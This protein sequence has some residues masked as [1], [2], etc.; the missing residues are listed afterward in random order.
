MSHI[1]WFE[2]LDQRADR[3]ESISFGHRDLQSHFGMDEENAR[4]INAGWIYT[5]DRVLPV[6]ERVALYLQTVTPC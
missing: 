1:A 5:Q 4:A 6:A 3:G 2:F